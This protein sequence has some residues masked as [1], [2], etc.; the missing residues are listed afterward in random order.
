MSTSNLCD[1]TCFTVGITRGGID[2]L[3]GLETTK[4]DLEI[5]GVDYT[6]LHHV[7]LTAF[8]K[9]GLY[10]TSAFVVSYESPFGNV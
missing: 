2:V 3:S 1:I 8:N 6:K 7:T 5:T 9:A 10:T 4:T